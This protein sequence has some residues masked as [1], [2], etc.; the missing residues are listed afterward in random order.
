MQHF[1]GEEGEMQGMC[2][3]QKGLREPR[4]RDAGAQ[5]ED[6]GSAEEDNN[7][8]AQDVSKQQTNPPRTKKK[9]GKGGAQE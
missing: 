3:Y 1:R 8:G 6:A 7:P 4:V 5:K 2:R 9:G